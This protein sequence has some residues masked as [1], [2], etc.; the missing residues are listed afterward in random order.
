MCYEAS[1]W[2]LSLRDCQQVA[3]AGLHAHLYVTERNFG[4]TPGYRMLARSFDAGSS[5]TDFAVDHNLTSPVTP[6]WT[7]IVASILRL[8]VA[9]EHLLFSCPAAKTVRRDLSLRLSTD[10]GVS[11]GE[12]KTLFAGLSGYSDLAMLSTGA[13]IIFENGLDTFSDR[14]SFSALPYSWLFSAA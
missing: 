9:V 11:W 13:G 3:S 14:I 7:G 2:F 5:L 10:Q 12:S 4:P 1:H 8:D 6:H